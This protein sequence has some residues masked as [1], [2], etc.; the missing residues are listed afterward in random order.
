MGLFIRGR[1]LKI[2]KIENNYIILSTPM[3]KI[4][5]KKEK[6]LKVY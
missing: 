1:S 6:I 5:I 4:V 3:H 2:V